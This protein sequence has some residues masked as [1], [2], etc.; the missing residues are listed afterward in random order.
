MCVPGPSIIM[1]SL[2]VSRPGLR[3]LAT[4]TQT[5]QQHYF[6]QF[7]NLL[8]ARAGKSRPGQNTIKS[9]CSRLL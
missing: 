6:P 1:M 7:A 4:L 2:L 3:P 8:S 9:N 5:K